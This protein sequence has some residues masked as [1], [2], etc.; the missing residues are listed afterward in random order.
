M[1]LRWVERKYSVGDNMHRIEKVLQIS[2][3]K[4]WSCEK[5]TAS[6]KAVF[7]WQ[8]VPTVNEESK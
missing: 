6:S 4:E 1:Q 5:C 2:V 7:E 3:F 8:D